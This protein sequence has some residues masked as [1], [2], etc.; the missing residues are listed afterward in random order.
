M[1]PRIVR[2]W[3]PATTPTKCPGVF[4]SILTCQPVSPNTSP[5]RYPR[6]LATP[7]APNCSLLIRGSLAHW[8]S[9]RSERVQ[10]VYMRKSRDRLGLKMS[11]RPEDLEELVIV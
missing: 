11:Q 1:D 4:C 2:G 9:A 8:P 6:T 10:L 5:S 3:F 7:P